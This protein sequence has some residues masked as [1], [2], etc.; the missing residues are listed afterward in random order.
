MSRSL[1]QQD[2]L[3]IGIVILAITS[4]LFFLVRSYLHE[5]LITGRRLPAGKN[6]GKVRSRQR[7]TRAGDRSLYLHQTTEID[8]SHRAGAR[9]QN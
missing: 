1:T 7:R 6:L 8:G 4:N 3:L 9:A 5:W 2:Y